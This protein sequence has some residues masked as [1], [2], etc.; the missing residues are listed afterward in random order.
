MPGRFNTTKEC[1]SLAL[2]STV[3]RDEDIQAAHVKP[4][5]VDTQND[6]DSDEERLQA[7]IDADL[8]GIQKAVQRLK[9]RALEISRDVGGPVYDLEGQGR[10]TDR[11]DDKVLRNQAKLDRLR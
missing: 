4:S 1:K 7:E 8:G 11:T 6:R 5:I 3:L 10:K 9:E 2:E